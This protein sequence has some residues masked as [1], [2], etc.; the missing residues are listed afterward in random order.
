VAIV[1]VI[2]F[3]TPVS[4]QVSTP[5]FGTIAQSRGGSVGGETSNVTIVPKSPQN[6][7]IVPRARAP[8]QELKGACAALVIGISDYKFGV[9]PIL[10]APVND[11]RSVGEELKRIGVDVQ[12]EV[13]LTRNQMRRAINAFSGKLRKGMTGLIFFSGHGIQAKRRSYLIPLDSD[14]WNEDE[15]QSK[16]I[17][18][19]DILAQMNETGADVK[20]AIIDSAR[21]NPFERRFRRGGAEGLAPVSAPFG[22]LVL[23]SANAGTPGGLVRDKDMERSLLVG[24]LLKEIRSQEL[25][26]VEV[27]QRASWGVSQRSLNEQTPWMIS[28]SLSP[29][30]SFSSCANTVRSHPEGGRN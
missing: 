25:P 27:F 28:S 15:V 22:S 3:Y 5:L 18:L 26:A 8:A 30:F 19:D 23:Y 24:E 4:H 10:K 17:S 14:I 7:D 11:A 12:V 29:T 1:L 2:G 13:N 20:I 6:E 16:G 21:R 9:D